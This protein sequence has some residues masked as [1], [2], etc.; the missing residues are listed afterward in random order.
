MEIKKVKSLGIVVSLFIVAV[1]AFVLIFKIFTTGVGGYYKVSAYP[2]I[3]TLGGYMKISE[4]TLSSLDQC[5]LKDVQVLEEGDNLHRAVVS[6]LVLSEDENSLKM[7]V[8]EGSSRPRVWE[9]RKESVTTSIRLGEMDE[10]CNTLVMEWV[11]APPDDEIAKELD[12]PSE[13]YLISFR[14]EQSAFEKLLNEALSASPELS[15]DRMG[16]YKTAFENLMVTIATSGKLGIRDLEF[17]KLTP[18]QQVL[19][20]AESI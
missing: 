20:P 1:F 4:S 6:G 8:K 15:N 14:I 7:L 16:L 10:E 12:L 17:D 19:E 5:P 2:S 18:I 9:M 11:P 3:A 13:G